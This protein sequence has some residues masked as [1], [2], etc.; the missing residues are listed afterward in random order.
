MEYIKPPELV[1][2]KIKENLKG[3]TNIKRSVKLCTSLFAPSLTMQI[4]AHLCNV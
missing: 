2:K 3:N 1:F 4:E